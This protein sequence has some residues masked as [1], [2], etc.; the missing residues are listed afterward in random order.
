MNITGNDVEPCFWQSTNEGN[1]HRFRE[2]R[3]IVDGVEVYE[4]VPA[5]GHVGSPDNFTP[6]HGVRYV[7]VVRD[8]GHIV[9]LVLTC[10]AAHNDGNN[11]FAHYQRNLAMQ[12]GWFMAAACPLASLASGELRRE[13]IVAKDILDQPVCKPGTYS[14]DQPCP[15]CK[16]EIKARRDLNARLEAERSAAYRDPTEKLIEANAAIAEKNNAALI[17][18]LTAAASGKK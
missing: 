11:S 10:A 9:P 1:N 4:R 14:E 13:H 7:N 18:A 8:G 12:R 3:R 2:Q 5:R 17:A 6:M 15:H 16:A